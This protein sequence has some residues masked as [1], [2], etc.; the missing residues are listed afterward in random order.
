MAGFEI[1]G[2]YGKLERLYCIDKQKINFMKTNK[3]FA[4]VAA[5]TVSQLTAAE[6]A[7]PDHDAYIKEVLW[8]RAEQALEHADMVFRIRQTEARLHEMTASEIK[9]GMSAVRRPVLEAY[10]NAR[11]C[12]D[13][14]EDITACDEF[15]AAFRKA[16]DEVLKLQCSP[17]QN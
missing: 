8:Q 9:A 17:E 4:L 5:A 10:F 7:Q 14:Q 12:L 11:I 13:E 1:E 6:T 15:F 2:K 3:L 16:C